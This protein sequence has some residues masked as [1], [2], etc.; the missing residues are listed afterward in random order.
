MEQS[1]RGWKDELERVH[2]GSEQEYQLVDRADNARF[3]VVVF[4]PTLIEKSCHTA[5]YEGLKHEPDTQDSILNTVLDPQSFDLVC[6]ILDSLM[7]GSLDS[8]LLNREAGFGPASDFH[9]GHHVYAA[10][11]K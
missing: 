2:Q 8:D 5:A 7:Q 11:Q 1:L 4:K 6:R 9:F 10:A 3:Y